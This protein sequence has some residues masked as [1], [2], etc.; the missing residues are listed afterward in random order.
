M[1]LMFTHKATGAWDALAKGLVDA[2][3]VI[4]ASWP[5][6]TEAEGSL[7][8]K[9]KNAAKST[10]FLVCRPRELPT[11]SSE[12]TYWEDVEPLVANVVREHVVEFQKYGIRG[13]DLYLSCFGPALEVF[14]EHWPMQRGR[15]LQQPEVPKGSMFKLFEDEEWDPYAVRPE[16]ALMA[17]RAAVKDW[18]LAQ[19]A[20]V[21]RH[22]HLDPVTEF[23][24]LAWDAFES[25]QFPADEALKLSRVVGTNFDTQLRDN[26]LELKGGDVILWDSAIRAKKG[27]LGSISSTCLLDAI[28]HAAWIGREQNTGIARDQLQKAELLHDDAFMRA[29]Q[30]VLNVLPPPKSVTGAATALAGAGADAGALERLR[31]LVYSTEIPA[32]EQIELFD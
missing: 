9:D 25:P 19:I 4:T 7:H 21:K 24:V 5:V 1:V 28:H 17:A 8:I 31:K 23:F 2:G 12:I 11:T 26:I 6:N 10:I 16:D 27:A 13:V 32:P 29:L 14:S 15:A 18:R 3:F 20:T 22:A 30:S